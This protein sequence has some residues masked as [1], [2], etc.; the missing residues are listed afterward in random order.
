MWFTK[1]IFDGMDGEDI[2]NIELD[3]ASKKYKIKDKSKEEED[4]AK[5]VKAAA[6]QDQD[7][8]EIDEAI[9]EDEE[10]SYDEAEDSDSESSDDENQRNSAAF[11]ARGPGWTFVDCKNKR[12][13]VATKENGGFTAEE[14]AV[15]TEMAMSRK[16]KREYIEN[17]YNRYTFDDEEGALPDWFLEDEK[18][19]QRPDSGPSV[20]GSTNKEL[21]DFYKERAKSAN[22]R[23][24]KKVA[25]AKA[26]KKKKLVLKRDRARKTAE[27]I[28]NQEDVSEREKSALVK[29]VYSKAGLSASGGK[30]KEKRKEK[31]TFV[32]AKKG[33][34]KRVARPKGVSG[35]YKVVDSRMKNDLKKSR[36]RAKRDK[37]K[38]SKKPNFKNKMNTS[39]KSRQNQAKFGKQQGKKAR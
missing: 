31:P 15:A 5:S 20:Q 7:E 37:V 13:R 21:V 35:N 4:A 18:V 1:P 32:V 22:V 26:R 33:V 16:K 17:S 23:T 27:G 14:L 8:M 9:E 19:H 34:G 3:L 11:A 39:K 38:D 30:L 25:E 36:M 6:A 10:S 12:E 29:S 24:I 2:T 28:L